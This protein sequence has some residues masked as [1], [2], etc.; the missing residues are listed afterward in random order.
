MENTFNREDRGVL[1]NNNS[2]GYSARRAAKKRFEKQKVQSEEI[3]SLK[4][5]L[6][7]L[8]AIVNAIAN[9]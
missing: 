7:E 9:V 8:K 2:S 1:V 4:T 6:E 5:Q 3:E